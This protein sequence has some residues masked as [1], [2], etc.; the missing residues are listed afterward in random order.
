MHWDINIKDG[1]KHKEV[2]ENSCIKHIQKAIVNI[3]CDKIKTHHK[4]VLYCRLYEASM[5]D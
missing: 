4:N 1:C 3:D 2:S 5:Y